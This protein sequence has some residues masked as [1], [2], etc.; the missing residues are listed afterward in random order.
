MLEG[1]AGSPESVSAERLMRQVDEPIDGGIFQWFQPLDDV[2]P[3][4]GGSFE[5]RLEVF[6]NLLLDTPV[7]RQRRRQRRRRRRR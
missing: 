1:F 2:L 3:E 4:V 7:N 6:V 5:E